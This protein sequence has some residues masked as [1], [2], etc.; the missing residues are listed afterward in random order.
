MVKD[1]PDDRRHG[2]RL[3]MAHESREIFSKPMSIGILQSEI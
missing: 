2:A 3:K 1:P